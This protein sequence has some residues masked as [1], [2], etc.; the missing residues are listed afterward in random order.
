MGGYIINHELRMI[1]PSPILTILLL[2][3][4]LWNIDQTQPHHYAW[5]EEHTGLH[6]L[7]ICTLTSH[8]RANYRIAFH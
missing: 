7:L 5:L 8:N 2:V 1:L 4:I 3:L 6:H